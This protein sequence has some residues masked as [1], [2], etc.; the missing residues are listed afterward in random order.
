MV[1]KFVNS[2]G[3]MQDLEDLFEFK[4]TDMKHFMLS[5]KYQKVY[6]KMMLS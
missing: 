6:I 3:K 4:N 1:Y 5:D 2:K